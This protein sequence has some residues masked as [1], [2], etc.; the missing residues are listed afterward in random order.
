M[1]RRHW[2]LLRVKKKKKVLYIKVETHIFIIKKSRNHMT[3][4]ETVIASNKKSYNF[5]QTFFVYSKVTYINI[6]VE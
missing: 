2:K 1:Y 6:V 5:L 4:K 3:E